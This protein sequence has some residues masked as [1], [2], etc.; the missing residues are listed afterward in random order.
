V[1]VYIH[2]DD[3]QWIVR[4]SDKIKLW[5]GERLKLTDNLVLHRLGGHFKGGSVLHWRTGN[6]GKGVLLTGDIIQVAADRRWVGFMYSYPNMIPLPA[7]KV[8]DIARRVKPLS[9]NRIYNA[10]RRV[11]QEDANEAVQRSARR[12]IDA[13][14]GR[15]FQ[16]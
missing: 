1:P 8:E 9:F 10:F 15:L 13:I 5:S 14:N 3:Q 7:A 11:V 16:T 2:E 4:P 6:Q 12:Y